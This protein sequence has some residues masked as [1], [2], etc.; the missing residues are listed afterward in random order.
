MVTNGG[1]HVFRTRLHSD[2]VY[3][4]RAELVFLRFLLR[5]DAFADPILQRPLGVAKSRLSRVIKVRS[6]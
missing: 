3:C 4:L 1:G 2:D 5:P 6:F